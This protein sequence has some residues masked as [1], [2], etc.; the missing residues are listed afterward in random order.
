MTSTSSSSSSN[1]EASRTV[2]Q[3][4][5]LQ[6][7]L[8]IHS[9]PHSYDIWC[10]KT[11]R[12]GS[13]RGETPACEHR[14]RSPL[15]CQCLG[16]AWVPSITPYGLFQSR[17][18]ARFTLETVKGLRAGRNTTSIQALTDAVPL[19]D[20]GDGHIFTTSSYEVE[21]DL[22]GRKRWAVVLSILEAKMG[23]DTCTIGPT[24]KD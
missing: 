14:P 6:S 15:T 24:G 10:R 16:T 9:Y 5:T 1:K 4:S 22:R 3:G 18:C 12:A 13:T 8:P 21:G 7:C 19:T 20:A 23:G 2:P 17:L 11:S